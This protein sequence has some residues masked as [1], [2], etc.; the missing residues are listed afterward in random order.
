MRA[1]GPCILCGV[2][3]DFH[4]NYCDSCWPEAE[5]IAQYCRRARRSGAMGDLTVQQ[6]RS[7]VAMFNGM[8]AY[9]LE[10][11]YQV[12]EHFVP[13]SQGGGTTISNCVPACIR[14]NA[15]KRQDHP[16]NV[17]RIPL[18]DMN[19]VRSFLDRQKLTF[20]LLQSS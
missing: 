17:T 6:W 15:R 8:C 5:R 16:D 4:I 13:I 12:M 10:R 14:C 19:R 20:N 2:K 18:E 11:P 3:T 1:K 9:C 7:I